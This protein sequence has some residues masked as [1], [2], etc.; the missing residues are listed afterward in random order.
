M[1]VHLDVHHVDIKQHLTTQQS[2]NRFQKEQKEGLGYMEQ[3][4]PH[5][6]RTAVPHKNIP[7]LPGAFNQSKTGRP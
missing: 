2:F 7:K 6:I 1:C 5:I 3:G 4:V